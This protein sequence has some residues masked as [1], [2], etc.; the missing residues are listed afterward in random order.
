MQ[1]GQKRL[2]SPMLTFILQCVQGRIRLL[3][4]EVSAKEDSI[5]DLQG[6][7]MDLS[8]AA[9]TISS[10]PA[11]LEEPTQSASAADSTPSAPATPERATQAASAPHITLSAPSTPESPAQAAS[12]VARSSPASLSHPLLRLPEGTPSGDWTSLSS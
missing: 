11:T 5:L 7:L 9:T 2:L 4:A 8:M 10:A 1:E 3:L 12:G 6:R